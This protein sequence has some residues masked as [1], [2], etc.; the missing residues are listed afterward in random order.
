MNKKEVQQRVLQNGKPL[1][2]NKFEWD[3]KTNTFSSNEKYLV[4]DFKGIDNCTFKTGSSCTFDTGSYCTFD[5]GSYCT[6]DT[7]SSCT[8]DTGS[9]CTFDTGSYCTFDTGYSCT[10]RTDSYC[11]FN[12]DYSCTFRTDSYCTF[13]TGSNCIF[14]TGS[15][16][17]FN[18]GKECVVV[19][20]DIYEIIELQ[21]GKEIKLNKFGIKGY[22]EV[23]PEPSLSGKEVEVK[24]DGKTYIAI[25]K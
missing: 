5:T 22:T 23:K 18:T 16:C 1:D 20:R 6:F 15:N 21:E 9:Y 12:T 13:K 17:I 10:F 19:R 25:I 11:T 14:N 2:L 8:F 4:L 3:E 24:L 7:G